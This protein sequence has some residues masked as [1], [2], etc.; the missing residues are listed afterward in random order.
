MSTPIPLLFSTMLF[1]LQRL[2]Q[3]KV[4]VKEFTDANDDANKF[5]NRI[6]NALPCESFVFCMLIMLCIPS[7]KHANGQ[8]LLAF[9]AIFCLSYIRKEQQR[10]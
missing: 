7:Y 1:S 9:R 8:L 5:K 10:L 3:F 6:S 4:D 2:R